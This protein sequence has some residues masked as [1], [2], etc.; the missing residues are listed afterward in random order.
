M[1]AV[2]P[3]DTNGRK[4]AALIETARRMLAEGRTVDLAALE[5]KVREQCEAARAAA[6]A[7]RV[8]LKETLAAIIDDLDRLVADL[9]DQHRALT[10]G[11]AGAAGDV[12]RRMADAYARARDGT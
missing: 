7:A 3:M 8:G 9:A 1:T 5:G 12:R 2:A 11:A 6:P 10:D 4:I